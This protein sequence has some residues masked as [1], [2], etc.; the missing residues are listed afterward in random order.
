[1]EIGI[2]KVLGASVESI[3]TLLSRDFLI[4][5]GL[6]IVI[7]TPIAWQIMNNWLQD[8]AYR[9]DIRWWMF[10]LAGLLALIIALTTVWLQAWT[11]AKANPVNAIKN[12]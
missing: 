1:K 10:A 7:A 8:F 9:I 12:E 2:R 5:V 3:I 11:A 6:A 4:L